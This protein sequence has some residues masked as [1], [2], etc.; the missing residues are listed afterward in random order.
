MKFLWLSNLFQ[1][2]AFLSPTSINYYI[3]LDFPPQPPYT[4]TR[5]NADNCHKCLGPGAL[6]ILS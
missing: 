2:T 1:I 5:I 4:S 6:I 3:T